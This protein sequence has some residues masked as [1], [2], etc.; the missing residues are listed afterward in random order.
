ML[1]LM[2]DITLE[3]PVYMVWDYSGFGSLAF[4]VKTIERVG[5]KI[6]KQ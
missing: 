4:A 3:E 6:G 5:K 2:E 1:H